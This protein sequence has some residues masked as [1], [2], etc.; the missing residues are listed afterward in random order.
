LVYEYSCNSHGI[1]ELLRPMSECDLPG[2]CP[3]C[4]TECER[5]P[6]LSAMRPDDMWHGVTKEGYGYFTSKSDYN[7]ELAR[8]NHVPLPD[9][10]AREDFD[11][12]ADNCRAENTKRLK[13]NMRKMWEKNLGPSGAGLGGADG[14]KIVQEAIEEAKQA[15]N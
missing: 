13:R 2:A 4:R 1:F 14:N 3:L 10:Q 6:S 8:R 7:A 5:V 11:K 9:R 12:H 15:N